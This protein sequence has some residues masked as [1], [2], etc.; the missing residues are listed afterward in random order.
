MGRLITMLTG[1]GAQLPAQRRPLRLPRPDTANVKEFG[2]GKGWQSDVRRLKRRVA[3]GRPV[4]LYR[5]HLIKGYS[6]G[7]NRLR[8]V[9]GGQSWATTPHLALEFAQPDALGRGGGR[10]GLLYSISVPAAEMKEMLRSHP[11]NSADHDIGWGLPAPPA[12]QR[13]QYMLDG[14]WDPEHRMR[15]EVRPVDDRPDLKP[16]IVGTV[17]RGSDGKLRYGFTRRLERRRGVPARGGGRVMASRR[18]RRGAAEY[19]REEVAPK[20]RERD[21]RPAAHGPG[22]CPG[23]VPSPAGYHFRTRREGATAGTYPEYADV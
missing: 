2:G 15:L 13:W 20:W 3:A 22:G 10:A 16:K 23:G 5:G 6:G 12:S 7:L 14:G 4:R 21:A 18:L 1:R 19:L 9:Y 8:R 17:G 11:R